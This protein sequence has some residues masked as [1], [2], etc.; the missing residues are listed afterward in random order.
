ML[1]SSYTANLLPII[2]QP[3][4]LASPNPA[5]TSA[6]LSDTVSFYENYA[7]L[8]FNPKPLKMGL[9]MGW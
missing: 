4:P 8:Y 6:R 2:Y 7:K 1:I 3:L 5:K 9:N